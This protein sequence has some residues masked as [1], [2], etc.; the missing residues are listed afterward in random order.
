IFPGLGASREIRIN[1]ELKRE[2]LARAGVVDGNPCRDDLE[3]AVDL[4]AACKFLLNVVIDDRGGAQAAVAGDIRAAFRVGARACERL[5][6]VSAPRAPVVVVSDGLPITGSLYQA[7]KLVA[8]AAGLL[9]DGGTLILVAACP[10][11]VGP[12]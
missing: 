9:C 1:H 5:Y 11:G 8:S 10:D 6:R 2:P 7:S 12:V 4:L 3:E